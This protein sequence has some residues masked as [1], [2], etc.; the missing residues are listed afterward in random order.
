MV[1]KI[2]KNEKRTLKKNK[3][4]GDKRKRRSTSKG[5]TVKGG[6]DAVF[7]PNFGGS[8]YSLNTYK[9]DLFGMTESSTQHSG[10][11]NNK[12]SRITRKRKQ[13]KK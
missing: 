3:K 5:R 9:N 13:N 1:N 10:G 4:M 2:T 11:G 8:Y 7:D 12:R 6:G